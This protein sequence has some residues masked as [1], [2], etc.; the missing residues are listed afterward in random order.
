[1]LTVKQNLHETMNGGNPDRF[2]NQFEFLEII[3]ESPLPPLPLHPGMDAKD[4]WGISWIWP[5]EQ[6]GAMPMH[7]PGRTVLTDINNW[8]DQVHPPLLDLPEEAWEPAVAHADSVRDEKYVSPF[9]APGLL[10]MCHHL[11]SI[12]GALTAFYEAPDKMHE[13]IDFLTGHELR[14]ADLIIDHLRPDALFHHDDW[15]SQYSTLMSPEVFR[16]FFVAPY[17]KIYS[18]W[19]ERGV[20]LI[21]H[22]SDSFAATL[23]PD[24]IEMGIDIWQ[25]VMTTNN[26]PGLIEK[27]GSQI[28]FMGEID[29]GP[30]DT[31]DWTSE[32]IR[33][34][35]ERACR[36][37]GT[38]YFI[39]CLTQGV[40]FSSFPEVYGA[41]SEAIDQMS[42]EMFTITE[43]VN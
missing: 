35:V 41:V 36:R 29:S 1:M 34:H 43:S 26:T 24:M 2:V 11:M 5:P 7:G 19:K 40:S 39:P 30:V 12:E 31:V 32:K 22:H 33:E 9:F 10:E 16:E 23:V 13:L 38:K 27:Y 3:M 37:C 14:I 15:G 18:Y 8:R 20:E 42:N 17:K 6:L 21:I 28:T 4:G 25:G